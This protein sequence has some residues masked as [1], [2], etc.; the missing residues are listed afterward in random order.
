MADLLP[1]TRAG[2]GPPLLLLHGIGTT[3][4]DFA[5]VMPLLT[6]DYDV[7]AV[8]LPGQGEAPALACRPTVSALADAIERDLDARGLDTVHVVGNSLGGRIAL[9]LATRGRVRSVVAIAP[10]GSS[11]VPERIVQCAAMTFSGVV[12]HTLRP[13]RASVRDR[14]LPRV[15]L[16]GLRARPW[17]ATASEVDAL[18]D[19]FGVH[20][21]WSLLTWALGADVPTH[22][23]RIRCPVTLVQGAADLLAPGQASRFLPFIADAR[24][25]IV[26]FAGHATQG[27]APEQIVGLVRDTTARA[28]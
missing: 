21:Y 13:L 22:L 1:S 18:V 2:S 7:I 19:G 25:S 15:L 14:H 3:R 9:E 12:F 11:T 20:S 26:P 27:D 5:R 8:D 28:A 6:T 23:D 4:S 17:A 16:G 10:S 24:L